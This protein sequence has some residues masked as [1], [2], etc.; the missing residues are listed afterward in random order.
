LVLDNLRDALRGMQ[1]QPVLRLDVADVEAHDHPQAVACP[2]DR[3]LVRCKIPSGLERLRYSPVQFA[4]LRRIEAHGA[5]GA[6]NVPP[7]KQSLDLPYLRP[8]ADLID[9][10][11]EGAAKGRLELLD[12]LV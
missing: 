11:Q 10:A 12:E 8:V 6:V 5:D 1:S 3:T 2:R 7:L 4:E 9:R